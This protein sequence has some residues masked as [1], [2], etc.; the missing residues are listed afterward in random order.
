M[1]AATQNDALLRESFVNDCA[2]EPGTNGRV[3]RTTYP[4][5]TCFD[6][7]ASERHVARERALVRTD[8]RRIRSKIDSTLKRTEALQ[9][10]FGINVGGH[11]G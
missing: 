10:S 9:Q 7:V 6:E 5:R 3:E 1:A 11:Y 8:E 4:G 2:L